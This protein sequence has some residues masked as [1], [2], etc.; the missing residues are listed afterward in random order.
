MTELEERILE[1][2]GDLPVNRR[3][4]VLDFALF[5]QQRE[6]QEEHAPPRQPV[7]RLENLYGDFWPDDEPIDNFIDAVREWR[8]EDVDLHRNET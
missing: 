7:Q 3:I 2:V 8:Q 5:L 1:A 4:Q 6:G